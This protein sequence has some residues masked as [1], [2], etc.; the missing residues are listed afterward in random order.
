MNLGTVSYNLNPITK[1]YQGPISAVQSRYRHIKIQNLFVRYFTCLKINL[2]IYLFISQIAILKNFV[3]FSNTVK[4]GSLCSFGVNF[5]EKVGGATT[6][7]L[8]LGQPLKSGTLLYRNL[9][10]QQKFTSMFY[11]YTLQ[12]YIGLLDLVIQNSNRGNVHV[13]KK[14]ERRHLFASLFQQVHYSSLKQLQL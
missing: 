12:A 8:S 3:I 7:F 4:T 2:S 5:D 1:S 14:P 9:A 10:A 13:F 11:Q 6:L